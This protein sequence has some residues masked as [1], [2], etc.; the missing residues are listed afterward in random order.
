M[1]KAV[2]GLPLQ[3]EFVTYEEFDELNRDNKAITR[4]GDG[5]YIVDGVF[6]DKNCVMIYFGDGIDSVVMDKNYFYNVY[7]EIGSV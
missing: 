6:F 5:E 7:R 1:R 2:I 4:N 3:V